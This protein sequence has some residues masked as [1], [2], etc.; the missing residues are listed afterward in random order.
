MET[1][2]IRFQVPNFLM[3]SCAILAA[4]EY[5]AV[6]IAASFGNK[7]QMNISY[8]CPPKTDTQIRARMMELFRQF[9]ETKHDAGNSQ[10]PPIDGKSD[11]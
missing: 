5:N 10:L 4:E 7:Q 11:R 2:K 3:A 6:E 8:V 9:Q 1:K